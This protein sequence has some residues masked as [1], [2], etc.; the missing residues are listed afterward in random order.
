M[1][2]PP[3]QTKDFEIPVEHLIL[4]NNDMI[5]IIAPHE[6]KGMQP[7]P[8]ASKSIAVMLGGHEQYLKF[9]EEADEVAAK[10]YYTPKDDQIFVES[11]NYKF[12]KK[13]DRFMGVKP[14][15]KFYKKRYELHPKYMFFDVSRN[16]INFI[17]NSP[18]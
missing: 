11:I 1:H 14:K 6:T 4:K 8:P 12:Q 7:K 5:R 16:R 3:G 18:S 15:H 13:C 17:V 2:Y 10:F 9:W